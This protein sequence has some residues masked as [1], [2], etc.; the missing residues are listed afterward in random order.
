MKFPENIQNVA[1]L[2]P[3]YLGFIFY[4]KSP[5]NFEGGIPNI[6]E[7]IKKTGVF[8]DAS[9]DF[10]IKNVKQH[11][12]K[13]IQLHGN[14]SVEFCKTLKLEASK[15]P[16]PISLSKT[17]TVLNKIEIW[18]VFSIKDEFDFDTLK[19]YEGIVDYF[20]F[21]TKGKEKGGNGY[22]FDWRVLEGY[23]STT[24]FI[25][26]GGIGL[27]EIDAIQTFLNKPE[28]KYL[29]AID[30][31]SKFEDSPGLKNI[32]NVKKLKKQIVPLLGE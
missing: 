21:D 26:S 13:A 19:P 8:V 14:E 17:D 11:G 27:A 25:L 2:L 16:N 4:E 12:F 29:Y 22:V 20:L 3:D 10:I 24:P 1:A 5:R 30:V 9:I 28:S 15:L 6:S 7:N 18:K 23:S 32:E 31:N